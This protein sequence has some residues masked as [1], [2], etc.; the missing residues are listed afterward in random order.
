[1]T[2]A[3]TLRP[4]K[5]ETS[6][7][8]LI[9]LTAAAAVIVPS[10][11]VAQP[12]EIRHDRREIRQDRHEL[13]QDR[14]ELRRDRRDIRRHVAYVAPYR[15]WSYRPVTVGYRLRPVFY[16]PRYY[17]VDYGSYHLR[18]PARGLRWIRYG[19]DLLLVNIRT[20]R[21]LQVMHYRWW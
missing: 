1:M 9:L 3:R 7:R 13:R 15:G 2:A 8:K 6:M 17:I 11:A 16:S 21:V 4:S 10:I 5:G 20:G 12:Q 18:A 19:D 14:R